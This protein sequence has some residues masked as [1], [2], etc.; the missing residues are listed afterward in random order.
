MILVYHNVS[1]KILTKYCVSIETFYRQME[2][3]QAYEVVYLHDYHPANLR[4][5]VLTFDDGYSDVIDYALPILEK[6]NYPFEIFVIGN[7]IGKI[8][9]YD[10]GR[11]PEA[12]CADIDQ[13]K[14]AANSLARIQW[15]SRNHTHLGSVPKNVLL[16]ELDLPSNLTDLFPEPH[17]RWLAYPYGDHTDEVVNIARSRFDG[18]VSVF[19]GNDN[20]LHQL[21][22]IEVTEESK[23]F[24]TAHEKDTAMARMENEIQVKN[25]QIAMM[26]TILSSRSWRYTAHLRKLGMLGSKIKKLFA[27]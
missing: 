23:F 11:E 14:R 8:N 12:R 13:L 22:R 6:W 16:H 25:T 15:H 26:K 17:F 7:Y 5:I 18:A 10:R 4:Q 27:R 9:S 21:N 20:D 2:Y 24:L 19:G 1:K 3:L